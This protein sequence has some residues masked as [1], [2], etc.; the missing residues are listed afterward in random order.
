MKI[1][2]VI[3]TYNEKKTAPELIRQVFALGIENLHILVVDDDSPDGTADIVDAMKQQY[4]GLEVLRR[5][6]KNGLGKAYVAAFKS[7]LSKQ[8]DII[9]EMDADWSHDPVYLPH[10]L[11]AV[12]KYDV[13]LGSRYVSGGGIKNWNFF[14]RLVS[15]FG[16]L[17]ARLVLR[18]PIKDL[19]GGYKCYRSTVLKKIGLD[20][21]SSHGYNFQIET[22]YNAYKYGFSII[23]LPI[24][25]TER[26]VG[27]SKFS[28]KIIFESFWKVLLL[29][30]KK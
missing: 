27:K 13:V 23:E 3:P 21:L 18:I 11:E 14:R 12:K 24:I 4:S 30:F 15:R 6:E 16:N 7:A 8:A 17:Y 29:R 2:I 19:T 22:T 25:F 1:V 5:P 9:C 28:A 26:T 10:M 20:N